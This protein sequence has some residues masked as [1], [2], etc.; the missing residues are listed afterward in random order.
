MKLRVGWGLGLV[1]AGG[2]ASVATAQVP[3]VPGAPAPVAAVPMA[4]APAAAPAPRNI[5][6]FFCLTPEQ[7][8]ACKAK[9]CNSGIGQLLSNSLQPVGALTGGVIG[10]CCPNPATDPSNMNQPPDSALGAAARIAA[11][12][13]GAKK[14]RAAVRY[15]GTVDCNYWPEARDALIN[16][17]RADRNECVRLEAAMALSRGCCCNKA[18]ITALVLTVSGSRADGNPAENCERVK[19]AA[20]MALAHCLDC[21]TEV[22]PV[23]PPTAVVP[24]PVLPVPVLPL[25]RP[26]G[27]LGPRPE[28]VPPPV[29]LGEKLSTTGHQGGAGQAAPM[30]YYER[31]RQVS[32]QEVIREAK[33]VLE[34]TRGE[35]GAGRNG[36]V[37]LIGT[38]FSSHTKPTPAAAPRQ[39][40]PATLTRKSEV[41]LEISP[42]PPS[43]QTTPAAPAPMPGVLVSKVTLLI[44][45]SP[46]PA[47][48]ALRS[49]VVSA[50]PAVITP[51]VPV[52]PSGP[53]MVQAPVRII[54]VSGASYPVPVPATVVAP[55]KK[56]SDMPMPE[57]QASKL[58]A[59]L[60]LSGI[61]AERKNAAEQLS[62]YDWRSQPHI[63]TALVESAKNDP[64]PMV[65]VS[66]VRALGKMKVNTEPAVRTVKM[67][68]N[69]YDAQ[70]RAE[71][72][73]ALALMSH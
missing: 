50:R 61:D 17:L 57:P 43:R 39:P 68:K 71:V 28:R 34:K 67:L 35:S 55:A 49:A 48:P 8:A 2:V 14:R 7:S 66:C 23:P 65:R 46:M 22:V 4:A 37:E 19:I 41:I 42:P 1:L 44:S 45:T 70:V 64:A 62:G 69:D 58:V 33:S 54:M 47:P 3:G 52:T 63:V 53:T 38:T 24:V 40:A 26:E 30:G 59:V 56:T 27:P 20:S 12:E 51:A 72:D 9:F 60:R 15:L 29:P 31:L 16:A 21:F 73:S 11:D 13:A 36:L 10:N 5:W 18:T 32:D 6:S 25:P